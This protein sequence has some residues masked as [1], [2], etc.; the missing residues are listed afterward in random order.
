M[1]FKNHFTLVLV[2]VVMADK[3][4]SIVVYRP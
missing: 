3:Y 1:H 4:G 2:L